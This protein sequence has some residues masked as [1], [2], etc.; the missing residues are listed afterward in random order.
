MIVD[1]RDQSVALDHETPIA[2]VGAG[3]AGITLA[4][5]FAEKQIGCLV[6]EAGGDGLDHTAQNPFRPPAGV[7][8]HDRNLGRTV[9]PL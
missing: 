3:A 2:I 1:A 6:L 8:R 5:S 9:H 4:L 7:R